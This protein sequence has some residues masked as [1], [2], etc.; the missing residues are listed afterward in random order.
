MT[1]QLLERRLDIFFLPP[2][3][4]VLGFPSLNAL[5]PSSSKGLADIARRVALSNAF[6][7]LF[8]DS[9]DIV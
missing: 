3:R 2:V 7:P 5:P 1:E 8:L 6:E 9:N 4:C